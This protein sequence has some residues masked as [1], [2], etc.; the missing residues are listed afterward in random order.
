LKATEWNNNK[1]FY[2]SLPAQSAKVLPT[3]SHHTLGELLRFMATF[4]A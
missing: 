1:K 2:H 3:L 4:V